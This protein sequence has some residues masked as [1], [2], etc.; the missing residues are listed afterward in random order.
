MKNNPKKEKVYMYYLTNKKNLDQNITLHSVI[1]QL[2]NP[3]HLL[4]DN[5]F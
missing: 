5:G 2:S 1:S 4:L 3:E